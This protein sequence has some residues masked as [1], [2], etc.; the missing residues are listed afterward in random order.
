MYH[1]LIYIVP[2]SKIIG[3]NMGLTWVL[4]APDGPHVGPMN[5]A[6]RGSTISW[7]PQ[8]VI[9]LEYT[10]QCDGVAVL[11][12]CD[13]CHFIKIVMS[14]PCFWEAWHPSHKRYFDQIQNSIKIGSS[15]IYDMPNRSQRNFSH[16]THCKIWSNFKFDRNI[17]SGTGARPHQ[18][19]TTCFHL[20]QNHFP[21]AL[22]NQINQQIHLTFLT[23]IPATHHVHK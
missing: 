4:S 1:A 22:H 17:V 11:L 6:I 9:Y 10:V 23:Y 3:A 13:S 8:T 12:G 19:E 15:L 5:L 7:S 2:D 20:T 21:A 16:V 18:R 14:Y